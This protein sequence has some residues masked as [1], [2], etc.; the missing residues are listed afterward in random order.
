MAR[1]SS[2]ATLA[3]R[4]IPALGFAI[5]AACASGSGGSSSGSSSSRYVLVSADLGSS[6]GDN[7]FEVV[8]RLRP[9]FLTGRSHDAQSFGKLN[10]DSGGRRSGSGPV[11]PSPGTGVAVVDGALPVIAYRDGARLSSVNDLKQ[12]PVASV[13]EVRFVPGPQAV[14]KYGTDHA[15]GVLLVTSK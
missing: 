4:A 1:H 8:Y 5:I 2:I 12:I 7:L 14:V 15:G 9:D 3:R 11:T 6:A 13:A 10:M